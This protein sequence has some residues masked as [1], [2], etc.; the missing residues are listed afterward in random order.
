MKV[1][2]PAIL[3]WGGGREGV[4]EE[5]KALGEAPPSLNEGQSKTN[6][7]IICSFLFR[8]SPPRVSGSAPVSYPVS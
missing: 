2:I 5:I 1:A 4:T 7:I 3:F 6:D 8:D